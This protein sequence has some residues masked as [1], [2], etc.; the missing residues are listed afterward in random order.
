MTTEEKVERLEERYSD[1]HTVVNVLA[2]KVDN[3]ADELHDFKNEMRDRDSRRAEDIREIRQSI[4]TMGKHVRNI[5]Y[6]TI[7]AI[8]AMVITVLMNLPKG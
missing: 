1:L 6:T 3:L 2:A 7:A 5:S 8:G 4:D